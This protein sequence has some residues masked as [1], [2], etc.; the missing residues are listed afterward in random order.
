MYGMH[1][2]CYEEFIHIIVFMGTIIK[3]CQFIKRHK[4]CAHPD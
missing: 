1:H 3:K 4:R 2:Q